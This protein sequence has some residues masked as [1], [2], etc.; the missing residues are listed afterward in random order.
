MK[1]NRKVIIL[2]LIILL[3]LIILFNQVFNKSS[4]HLHVLNIPLVKA[5][6]TETGIRLVAWLEVDRQ[7]DFSKIKEAAKELNGGIV[8]ET[9]EYLE[10]YVPVVCLKAWKYSWISPQVI[11]Y[12]RF[13]KDGKVI[14]W[15]CKGKLEEWATIFYWKS[16]Y[17]GP[18]TVL[19][20]AAEKILEKAFPSL[21][22]YL[23]KYLSNVKYYSPEFP[24][25]KYIIIA[26]GIQPGD[27]ETVYRISENAIVYVM[28]ILLADE[29]EFL[30]HSI[31]QIDGDKIIDIGNCWRC[32]GFDSKSKYLY[33]GVHKIYLNDRKCVCVVVFVVGEGE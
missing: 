33:S 20:A 28:A 23:P 8:E 21:V 1:F 32:V 27:G 30:S 26:Y 17:V 14:S 11:V 16:K 24:K 31:V 15:L 5:Q 22:P 18:T 6:E 7:L 9:N 19:I 13:Y 2:P 10:V 4:N 29:E 12:L 25:A 3:L